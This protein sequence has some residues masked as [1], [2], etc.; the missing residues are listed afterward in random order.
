MF[1]YEVSVTK[2]QSVHEINPGRD[3]GPVGPVRKIAQ[4]FTQEQAA[5]L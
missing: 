4:Y 5:R 3:G 2:T 1:E